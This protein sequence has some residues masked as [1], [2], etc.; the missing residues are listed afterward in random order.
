MF[1]MQALSG[2]SVVESGSYITGPYAAMLLADLGASV[3]K[4][5]RPNG[6]DPYRAFKSGLYSNHFRAINRNKKSITLDLNKPEGQKIMRMLLSKADIF[7]ENT[8]NGYLNRVGLGFDALKLVNP[9]LVYVSITGFGTTG[10]YSNRPSYDTIGMALSGA[11]SMYVDAQQ[12]RLRGLSLSDSVT[13]MYSCYAALAG[14]AMRERTGEAVRVENSMLAATMAFNEFSLMDFKLTGIVPHNQRRSQV[15]L[16]WA[17]ACSDGKLVALHLSSPDKFWRGLL[18]VIEAPQLADDPRFVNRAARIE[19]HGALRDELAKRFVQHPRSH[20]VRQFADA[21]VPFAPI[22][23]ASEVGEDLQVKAM[24]L[25]HQL[26]HPS[27]EVTPALKRPVLINGS[28]DEDHASAPPVLGEH[29]QEI[30]NSLGYS[31]A[32][33]AGLKADQVI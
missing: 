29:N 20:W 9:R 15:N 8:R 2:I 1:R 23:D 31:D 25:W 4:V 17:L 30:L 10:P 3:I 12:P 32:Q 27:G 24:G 11:L 16:S 21:E 22:Y 26:Q 14:L 5:E 33:I 13:G 19:N 18:S 28:R 7:L 6:G